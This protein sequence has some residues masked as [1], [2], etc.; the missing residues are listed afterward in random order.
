M[1]I[2]RTRSTSSRDL[3]VRDDPRYRVAYDQL[4]ESPAPPS[5]PILGPQREIR[6]ITAN[7]VAEIFNGGDVQAALTAAAEQANVLIAD[8]NERN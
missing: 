3:R 2:A 5:G 6:S 1:P 7:A 8:Y 4:I